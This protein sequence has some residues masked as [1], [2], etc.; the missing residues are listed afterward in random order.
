[1]ND[2]AMSDDREKLRAVPMTITR[3]KVYIDR[4]HRHLP[5]V[6]GALFAVAVARKGQDEPC[7]VALFARPPARKLDD[8]KTGEITRIATD[9]TPNACSKLIGLCR[10]I[11]GIMGYESI[12][13]V[14]LPSEGGQS[15]RGAGMSDPQPCG[16]GSWNVP[17]R[18]REQKAP[19]CKK[20]RWTERL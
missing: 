17:S 7:G 6:Q 15:L 13:T 2:K 18:P 10:R 5:K 9:G 11:A 1:M 14:T 4:W 16:G 12:T 19:T 8:G 3:A 20:H